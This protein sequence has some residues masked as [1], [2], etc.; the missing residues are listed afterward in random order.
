MIVTRKSQPTTSKM[1]IIPRWPRSNLQTWN[2]KSLGRL[3]LTML[4]RWKPDST[5]FVKTFTID[6]SPRNLSKSS[7][8]FLSPS[9][10]V[11]LMLS[12]VLSLRAQELWRLMMILKEKWPSTTSAEKTSCREWESSFKPRS[13]SADPM[14]SSQK[15]LK[16]MIT[17]QRWNPSLCN[18]NTKSRNLRRRNRNRRTKSSTKPLR[19]LLRIKG[20]KRNVIMSKLSMSSRKKLSRLEVTL[21]RKISIRLCWKLV[22]NQVS[23]QRKVEKLRRGSRL[24]TKSRTKAMTTN[25]RLLHHSQKL[26]RARMEERDLAD[27]IVSL[28]CKRSSS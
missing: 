12:H 14:I 28:L 25:S 27:S 8:R 24:W 16:L 23:I 19:L 11:W 6:L 22:P 5:K 17:C 10:W 3:L 20:I 1:K 7:G 13:L 2:S 9:I 15:C 21:R 26:R 4:R 18:S